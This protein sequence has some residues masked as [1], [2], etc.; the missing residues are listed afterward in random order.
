MKI[1]SWNV[2]GL[3]AIHRKGAF[4]ALFEMNPDI[5]CF[6]ETKAEA[7]QLPDEVR[8]VKGYQVFFSHSKKRKGYSGVSIYTKIKPEKIEY[9]IG[10][11]D[12]DDEGRLLILYIKDIVIITG[13]FPNGGSGPDRLQYKLKF[14]DA[15][16]LFIDTLK[17]KGKKIIFCGD[18]N[19]AHQAIDLARPKENEKNTG[20]L[21]IERAWIDKVIDHG[22]IDIFRT[23]HPYVRDAYTYW[24]M[25]TGARAR[26]VGWRIDY[27]FI[28]L[29]LLPKIKR[30]EI[31][32][33]YEGSDHCPIV[34]ELI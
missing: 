12:F 30:T 25:K 7:I 4:F 1:I 23:L 21:P 2:N 13:Y 10:I 14:Y 17:I 16:L 31:I 9:G 29:D 33:T 19:T 18:V 8:V 15:F 34:L 32:S 5:V 6:Q 22:Y 26:N 11:P 28:S 24:D 27:F 3:R 20:F